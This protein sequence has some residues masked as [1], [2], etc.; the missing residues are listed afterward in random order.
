VHN[1]IRHASRHVGE[2]PREYSH[3]VAHR[4]DLDASVVELPLD[5]SRPDAFE[6]A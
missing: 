1:D 2:V 4:L 6:C 3:L 5:R